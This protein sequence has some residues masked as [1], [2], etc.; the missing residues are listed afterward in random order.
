MIR[1]TLWSSRA[2]LTGSRLPQM[3]FIRWP[4]RRPFSTSSASLAPAIGLLLVEWRPAAVERFDSDCR[5]SG[6]PR[7]A[8][9]L[10]NAVAL[11]NDD[12]IPDTV[13]S[14]WHWEN[15]I[16]RR[17]PIRRPVPSSPP[18]PPS[19]PAPC[20]GIK[21]HPLG[22][23][24]EETHTRRVGVPGG[25]RDV[26]RPRKRAEPD[27]VYAPYDGGS[28]DSISKLR[29][30]PRRMSTLAGEVGHDLGTWRPERSHPP[31]VDP[32]DLR[33]IAVALVF[34]PI[35]NERDCTIPLA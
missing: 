6:S 10:L 32:L 1:F 34:L 24:A 28:R 21:V 15:G 14:K 26:T 9:W 35:E 4:D 25:S 17:I 8:K 23:G 30:P 29:E 11:S 31:S 33:C 20:A 18:L 5:D 2:S 3:D 7:S 19:P 16:R 13:R 27:L 22:R 12:A